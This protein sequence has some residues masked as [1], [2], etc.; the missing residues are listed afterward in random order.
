MLLAIL[1]PGLSLYLHRRQAQGLL[2]LL[3]Q[4]TLIGWPVC[5]LLAVRNLKHQRRRRREKLQTQEEWIQQMR[6]Q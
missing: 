4:C 5:S 6:L 3:L 1:I 2:C